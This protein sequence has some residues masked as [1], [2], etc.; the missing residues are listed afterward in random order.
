MPELSLP[1]RLNVVG[2]YLEGHYHQA[3]AEKTGVSKGSVTNIVDMLRDGQRPALRGID[4]QVD[5]LRKVA[6]E[7]NRHG[8]SLSQA[9]VGVVAFQ[10]FTA[11]GIPPRESG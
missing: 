8:L 1:K 4:D 2:L 11:L 7:I 6:V 5:V 3:I 9:A 10:S